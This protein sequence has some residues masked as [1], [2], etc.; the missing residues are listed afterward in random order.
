MRVEPPPWRRDLPERA[1]LG[2]RD[3]RETLQTVLPE[4]LPA[5]QVVP[6]QQDALL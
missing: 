4:P 3:L 1:D 2:V 6:G 5:R